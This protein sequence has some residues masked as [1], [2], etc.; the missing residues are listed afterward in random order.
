MSSRPLTLLAAGLSLMLSACPPAPGD[1]GGAPDASVVDAG[2]GDGGAALRWY[3][4]CGDPVCNQHRPD[5]NVPECSDE[6]EGAAC[7]EAGDRCD[8]VNDCNSHLLCTDED[9]TQQPGGCPISQRALKRDTRYLSD[10]DVDALYREVLGVKLARYSYTGEP[11][12]TRARLGFF[13]DDQRESPAVLPNGKQV[14][15]YGYTSMAVAALQAQARRIRALE[16][17]LQAL[18]DEVARLK[19]A[20]PRAAR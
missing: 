16:E 15:V 2:G 5:P 11:E 9:P 17:D 10:V 8:P 12:G 20:G 14:D 6:V 7:S 18:R 19:A 3:A 13:I 1:D 4:T